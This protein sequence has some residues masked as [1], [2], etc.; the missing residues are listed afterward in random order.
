MVLLIYTRLSKLSQYTVKNQEIGKI[1]NMLSN[2]FN[3]IETKC[4]LLFI[5]LSS[6]LTMCG[7]MA[8]LITRF[9]WPGVIIFGVTVAIIPF[10]VLVGK[11]S[12]SLMQKLNVYKD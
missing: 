11:I 4:P 1:I 3:T 8:I 9:G 5:S 10:Q 12:G 7:I 2:D 6:P